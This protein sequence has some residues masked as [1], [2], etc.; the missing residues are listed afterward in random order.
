MK[1]QTI[2]RPTPAGAKAAK[3]VP[4]PWKVTPKPGPTPDCDS[5][6]RDGTNCD[7]CKPEKAE[8]ND[9]DY[10]NAF[11]NRYEATMLARRLSAQAKEAKG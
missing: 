5:C 11:F 1:K 8:P 6:R 4:P 2:E 7:K 9:Q 10:Q 3:P